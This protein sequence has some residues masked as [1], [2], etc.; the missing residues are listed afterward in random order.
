MPKLSKIFD[1]AN[2]TIRISIRPQKADEIL[3]IALVL[4]RILLGLQIQTIQT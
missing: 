3:P 1:F 2:T 4:S